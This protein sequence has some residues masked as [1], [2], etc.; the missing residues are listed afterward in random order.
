TLVLDNSQSFSGLISGLAAADAIDLGDIAF[1]TLQSPTFFRTATGGMLVVSD[2]THT[3]LI[4]LSG[5]FSTLG[6]TAAS[7]GQGGTLIRDD[8]ALTGLTGGNAVEGTAAT[9]VLSGAVSNPS[10]Q[11]LEYDPVSRTWQAIAN[12]TGA[13]F[14]PGEADEGKQLEVQISYTDGGG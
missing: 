8:L 2:G 3:S 6:F 11:W 4:A 1:A 14:T 7:A 9:V 13:S 10:Y 5:D 12:A